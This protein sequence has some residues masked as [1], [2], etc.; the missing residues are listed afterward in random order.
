MIW[1]WYIG[2]VPLLLAFWM[3]VT[4]LAFVIGRIAPPRPQ[5]YILSW[6]AGDPLSIMILDV[7]LNVSIRF[8]P[9]PALP[10]SAVGD[11]AL[12]PDGSHFVMKNAYDLM[13][14]DNRGRHQRWL[15]Q[16]GTNNHAPAWSPDGTK[17]AFVSERDNNSEIYVMDADGSNQVRLTQNDVYDSSPSWSP[18]G[19]HIAF[20][21]FEGDS[22][23]EI[24][25]MDSDGNNPHP[26]TSNDDYDSSPAWS[27]DGQHILFTSNRA[28]AAYQLYVMN[29]DGSDPHVLVSIE[30]GHILP[31][32]AWSPDGHFIMFQEVVI[33]M[34]RMFVANADGS[35]LRPLPNWKPPMV[36]PLWFTP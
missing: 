15:T 26:L 7:D 35:H 5:V 12:S 18:D 30:G 3:G 25:V 16:D 13:V 28:N 4:A 23:S 14:M 22:D 33:N 9:E 11:W 17:I 32:R 20:E 2:K 19:K 8:E 31:A 6:Q 27:P 29:A 21:S 10:G 34:G 24:Y 1:R 36:T